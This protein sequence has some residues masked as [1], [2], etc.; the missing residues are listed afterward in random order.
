MA[1]ADL[2][3][4]AP[5]VVHSADFGS[6]PVGDGMDGGGAQFVVDLGKFRQKMNS[7]GVKAGIS[8]DWDRP[9]TMSGSNGVGLASVGQGVK[10]NS[11]YVHAHIMPYYIG[12]ITEANTWAYIQ[13]QVTWLNTTVGLPTMI[14]ETQV[15]TN[16][17]KDQINA[18]R[19]L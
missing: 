7:Y 13:P 6:E 11:D 14:T 12:D 3:P 17:T 5:Y 4:I 19:K 16:A 15:S 10:E 8:E 2:G 18:N 9:G 1:S